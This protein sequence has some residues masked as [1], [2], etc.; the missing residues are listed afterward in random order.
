MPH[1]LIPGL[2]NIDQIGF[3]VF[4]LKSSVRNYRPLFGDF[5]IWEPTIIMAADYRGKLAD[6]TL[7]IA[8]A[9]TG[10]LEIELIQALDGAS[11]HVEAADRGRFGMHHL[12][13]RVADIQAYIDAAKSC[14]YG[15]IWYKD[16]DEA[17]KFAYLER[18]GDPLIIEFL[19]M[20]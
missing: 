3:V 19:Q 16:W 17:T 20:P 12:R 7:L 14:G 18:S 6:C 15:L 9:H 10:E 11:P 2:P 1:Q 8:T 13:Y 4:D 5:D